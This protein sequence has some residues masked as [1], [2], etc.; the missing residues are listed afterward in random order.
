MKS[1]CSKPEHITQIIF[2]SFPYRL[3]TV[4]LVLSLLDLGLCSLDVTCKQKN[5][6]RQSTSEHYC[7]ITEFP[8]SNPNREPYNFHVD[9]AQPSDIEQVEFVSTKMHSLNVEY[10]PNQM[11]T[12]FPN[13]R[14]LSMNATNLTELLPEDFAGAMN[15]IS[16]TL[17]HNKWKIIRS[18]VFSPLTEMERS[19]LRSAAVEQI[20]LKFEYP[21]HKL[22]LLQLHGNEISEIEDYSFYGLNRLENLCLIGNQLTVIRRKTFAGLPKLGIL[23]L[24][25][26]RIRTIEDGALDLPQLQFLI[27]ARNELKR[28]SNDIFV[29]LPALLLL[30]LEQNRLE[31]IG[32]SLHELANIDT[33]CLE[34]NR[35]QDLDL[36][37]L[38]KLP[39]LT[40]LSLAKSGL[41]LSTITIENGHIW[42]SSLIDLDLSYNNISDATEL[43]KL[44][45][46]PRIRSLNLNGNSLTDLEVGSQ[47]TLKNILPS[48]ERVDIG[49]MMINSDNWRPLQSKNVTIAFN[50]F[51][52]EFH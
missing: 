40:M 4:V 12:T 16:L 11:F 7:H 13:L 35:I 20:D 26:N 38:A 37:A 21:L 45:I 50:E 47:K 27:L 2:Y 34:D 5:A 31:H 46:F 1:M 32:Q 15:L 42:N 30:E 43:N 25:Q 10:V 18:D 39:Y 28:L 44:T 33:I 22:T 9:Y 17:D 8:P 52:Y 23:D 41:K 14:G 29:K 3:I 36:T 48:L 24:E 6:K 49:N 19:S 51:K